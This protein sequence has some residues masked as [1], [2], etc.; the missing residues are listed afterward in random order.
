MRRRIRFTMAD[1]SHFDAE[2]AYVVGC[3]VNR[4]DFQEAF[5]KLRKKYSPMEFDRTKVSKIWRGH[6]EKLPN[7][8]PTRPLDLSEVVR[9]AQGSKLDKSPF[10]KDVSAILRK[11]RRDKDATWEILLYSYAKFD[12]LPNLC[13]TLQPQLPNCDDEMKNLDLSSANLKRLKATYACVD[14]G[15]G[16]DLAI[17]NEGIIFESNEISAFSDQGNI[18]IHISPS[19]SEPQIRKVIAMT[20]P[21]RLFFRKKGNF[22]SRN[23]PSPNILKEMVVMS[24]D[25]V[26]GDDIRKHL[27]D[28]YRISRSDF[29]IRKDIERAREM[30]F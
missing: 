6:P 26:K 4:Q 7:C 9:F 30:G 16:L 24:E 12:L 8:D 3:I 15:E 23:A 13:L 2:T 21:Y 18:V 20:K 5:F 25:G 19:A 1:F 14:R 27:K 28:E 17:E 29:Q 11:L 10:D 22:G